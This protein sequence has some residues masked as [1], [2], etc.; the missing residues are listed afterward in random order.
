MPLESD[1]SDR[2][3]LD[4]AARVGDCG[5][6]CSTVVVPW[7]WTP[8]GGCIAGGDCSCVVYVE[9]LEGVRRPKGGGCSVERTARVRVT[10]EACAPPIEG[11]GR[12]DLAKV[13]SRT[14][15]IAVLRWQILSAVQAAM[16][17]G[18]VCGGGCDDMPPGLG[19]SCST[20]TPVEPGW[21]PLG[22]SAGCL[23]YRAEWRFVE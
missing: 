13:R 8:P 21:L 11:D 10:L 12:W 17:A 2:L 23:R 1:W 20:W 7:D 9:A 18:R 5:A 22:E 4:V 3:A 16:D 19:T 14:R 6:V 15:E